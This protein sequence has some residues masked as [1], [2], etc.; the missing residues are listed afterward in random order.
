[1]TALA[2]VGN[3]HFVQ[4]FSTQW[5][6][7]ALAAGNLE[8]LLQLWTFMICLDSQ[9]AA[10]RIERALSWNDK[11]PQI[12]EYDGDDEEHYEENVDWYTGKGN[13]EL[14]DS[15]NTFGTPTDAWRS[16]RR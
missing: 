5:G 14:D 2:T 3:L 15:A 8:Q 9:R 13:E 11:D 10:S 1:M 6:D 4:A 12:N 7:S 16:G